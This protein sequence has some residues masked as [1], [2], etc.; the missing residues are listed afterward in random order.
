MGLHR[1][2]GFSLVG[3]STHLLHDDVS[4]LPLPRVVVLGAFVDE[5]VSSQVS[6][7]EEKVVGREKR[8]ISFFGKQLQMSGVRKQRDHKPKV[9]QI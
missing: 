2:S 9:N 4:Q 7:Q 8:T 5:D 1:F 6:L 3:T